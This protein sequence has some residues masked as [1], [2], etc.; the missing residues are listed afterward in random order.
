MG[1]TMPLGY[2]AASRKVRAGTS[3]TTCVRLRTGVCPRER[4]E[5]FNFL[6]ASTSYVPTMYSE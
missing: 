2:G 3:A 5:F 1:R 6:R 4:A